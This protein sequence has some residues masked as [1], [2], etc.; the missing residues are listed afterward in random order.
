MSSDL[1]WECRDKIIKKFSENN[2][3]E[4]FWMEIFHC[5]HEPKKKPKECWCETWKFPR[6]VDLTDCG[7]R[8]MKPNFCPECGRELKKDV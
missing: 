5:H 1:C 7:N 3:I 2:V 6:A 4:G 8:K